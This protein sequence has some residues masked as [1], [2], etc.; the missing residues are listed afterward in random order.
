LRA[1]DKKDWCS[2]SKPADWG[3]VRS[4]KSA[5]AESGGPSQRAHEAARTAHAEE[6]T[7]H[8]EAWFGGLDLT[9]RTGPS[10]AHKSERP[11]ERAS[12]TIVS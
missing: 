9:S 11:E 4:L 1:V 6:V 12:G 10:G 8:D 7:V 2:T 5:S 3:S